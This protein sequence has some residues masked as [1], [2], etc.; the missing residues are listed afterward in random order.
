MARRFSRLN[1]ALKSIQPPNATNGTNTPPDGSV[2][3]NFADYKSGAKQPNYVRAPESLP[4]TL[5]EVAIKPF[6]FPAAG[7]VNYIVDLS[8]RASTATGIAA[9]L[10]AGNA[11]TTIPAGAVK[12]SGFIPAKA[13]IF[14]PAGTQDNTEIPSQITGIL[15]NPREGQSYTVPYG[16]AAT[17]GSE[18]EVRAAMITAATPITNATISFRSERF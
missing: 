11:V 14:A 7:T 13:V 17:N 2:L 1:Y 15:Y 3:K 10:A 18:S 8:E 16:T 12:A 6:A 4:G 9:V 5:L